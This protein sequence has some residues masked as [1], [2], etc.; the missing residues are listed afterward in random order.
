MSQLLTVAE[1]VAAPARLR[2]DKIGA[3]DSHR[4]LS[5]RR[6]HERASRL[7]NGLRG[8]GLEPG[9]RVA[10][11]AYNCVEWMEIYVALARAGLVAVPINFRL[12]G[13]EIEYIARHCEA[14][15]FIVQDDLVERVESIRDRLDI[16][17]ERLVRFGAATAPDG[18]ESYEAVIERASAADGP[19]R[20]PCGSRRR[21]HHSTAGPSAF[22]TPRSWCAAIGCRTRWRDPVIRSCSSTG[23]PDRCG[24]GD[25][26]CRRSPRHTPSTW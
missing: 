14:R 18:W 4:A 10:V 22:G 3:R 25:A 24:G 20:V 5:F 23:S 11:L 12:V 19:R 15:A 13:P 6:W 21:C 7:A 16:P 2:P 8:L 1:V 9:D 26:T 17:P